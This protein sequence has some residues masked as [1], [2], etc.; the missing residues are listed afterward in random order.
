MDIY[1]KDL[2]DIYS[3]QHLELEELPYEVIKDEQHKAEILVSVGGGSVVITDASCDSCY[4]YGGNLGGI[5]GFFDNE[6]GYL[7]ET[8]SDEDII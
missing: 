5:M 8:S 1:R 7:K 6:N 4:I 2:T 3:S